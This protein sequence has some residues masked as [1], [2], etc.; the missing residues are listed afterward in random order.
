MH[1]LMASLGDGGGG[2]AQLHGYV[3]ALESLDIEH[4]QDD[5][6]LAVSA[7]IK[8]ADIF[9]RLIKFMLKLVVAYVKLHLPAFLSRLKTLETV[10]LH[11]LLQFIQ[12]EESET[13]HHPGL[14]RHAR[15]PVLQ[16]LEVMLAEIE[17]IFM[18][19]RIK[20]HARFRLQVV[21]L[22]VDAI[23]H[24]AVSVV[25]LPY[26]SCISILEALK[27]LVIRQL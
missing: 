11:H 5:A 12:Q 2:H 9:Y 6:V 8:I 19:Q 13:I 4:L 23:S 10:L 15:L 16:R 25:I 14:E 7:I 26:Y 18:G 17:I 3:L 21:T 27:N 22:V 24:P 1:H 20:V